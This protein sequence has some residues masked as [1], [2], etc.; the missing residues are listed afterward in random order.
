MPAATTSPLCPAAYHQADWLE[1]E[2]SAIF[3]KCWLFAGLS[4]Q[5]ARPGDFVTMDACGWPVLV[6][7]GEN[8]LRAFRNVCSHRFSELCSVPCGHGSIRCRYHG[9]TY[10]ESGHATGIPGQRE[11]F[12]L[13]EQQRN[14]LALKRYQVDRCGSFVFIRLSE[15]GP[16]LHEYLGEYALVLESLGRT[17]S[18]PFVTDSQD[19]AANWKQGVENTIEPYHTEFVHR[20]TLIAVVESHGETVLGDGHSRISH[21]LFPAAQN[22]WANMLASTQLQPCRDFEHYHHF[23]I[24][25][26]LCL[27]LTNGSLL[28]I[29]TFE[30][31]SADACRLSF[32]LL[33]PNS[34]DATGKLT[35]AR[36]ALSGYLEEF[37][38]CVLAED[39]GPVEACQRGVRS[40]SSNAILGATEQR[41][42]A[43]HQRLTR[44]IAAESPTI[45]G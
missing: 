25:P 12:Q 30:P 42:L 27:G 43:F 32:R 35:S 4:A 34:D 18:L 17:F 24:Y 22:W 45:A 23:F 8:G 40:A 31:T 37:N 15:N 41:I 29:Q 19:W 26:N 21:R 1:R 38:Q 14:S 11:L 36:M 2:R 13:D 16:S 9:W 44:E 20:D 28:S 7:C 33:L 39:R 3:E 5:L 6:Y 10:D